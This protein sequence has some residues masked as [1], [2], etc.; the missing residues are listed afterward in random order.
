MT[1]SSAAVLSVAGV[2][3]TVFNS[4]AT[5]ATYA[6]QTSN[7]N[8]I[9][10]G[11]GVVSSAGGYNAGGVNVIDASRNIYAATLLVNLSS[12]PATTGGNAPTMSVG[13]STRTHISHGQNKLLMLPA[14]N[15]GAATGDA[16]LYTWISEPSATWTG[17]GIAR[18]MTN[19]SGSFPRVNSGLSGQM[20][21][22]DEGTGISFTSETSGGTRYY[23]L[24]L[25]AADATFTGSVTA[26]TGFNTASTAYNS[27]QT[28]NGFLGKQL[29]FTSKANPGGS[30]A[31]NAVVYMDS[32]TNKLVASVNGGGYVELAPQS[33]GTAASPTFQALTISDAIQSNRSTGPAIYAPNAYMQGKGYVS[34]GLSAYNSIQ[35]DAGISAGTGANGGFYVGSTQVINTS[36]QF[37]G[38]GIAMP[39]YGISASG[40]NPYSG[41]QYFG[42]TWN[43]VGTFTISGVP[44][45]TLI[46]KGGVLVSAS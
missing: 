2:A 6:F 32:G 3:A 28:G 9:V 7:S 37:V 20:I 16:G 1:L 13:G 12:T 34:S 46:F 35:S 45:T 38:L 22:F 4:T 33:L 39:S 29:M 14:A 36:G 21:R 40:F 44:Y 5:G 43:V 25:T 19:T 26:T 23:P 27:I 11:N 41:T 17:A 24:T 8:F 10:N 18:N 30:T 15:N 42:Q 31:G